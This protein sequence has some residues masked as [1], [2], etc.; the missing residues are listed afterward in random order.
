MAGAAA[1]AALDAGM[2]GMVAGATGVLAAGGAPAADGG[3][4]VAL[5]SASPQAAPISAAIK[6]P[7]TTRMKSRRPIVLSVLSIVTLPHEPHLRSQIR[8]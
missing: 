1:P 6:V 7:P 2:V 8:R 4:A 3:V 5:E